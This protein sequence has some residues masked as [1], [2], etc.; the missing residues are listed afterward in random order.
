MSHGHDYKS[1]HN[2]DVFEAVHHQRKTKTLVVLQALLLGMEVKLDEYTY[3]L[4]D[5]ND[6]GYVPGVVKD[7]KFICGMPD[8]SF[9]ALSAMCDRM[10]EEEFKSMETNYYFNM[11]RQR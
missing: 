5:S 2:E 1:I 9:S 8:L 6:G 3:R 10:S 4:F 7:G 11:M